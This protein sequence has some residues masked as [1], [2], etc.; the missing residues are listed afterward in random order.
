LY[1]SSKK[2]KRI[3]SWDGGSICFHSKKRNPVN[4]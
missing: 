2:I 3:L 4:M 1:E